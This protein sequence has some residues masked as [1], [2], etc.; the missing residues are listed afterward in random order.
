M[1]RRSCYK[2]LYKRMIRA[3]QMRALMEGVLCFRDGRVVRERVDGGVDGDGGG[4]GGVL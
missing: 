3:E 2:S 1:M 4:K